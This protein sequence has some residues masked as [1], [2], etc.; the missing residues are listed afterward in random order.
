MFFDYITNLLNVNNPS[1]LLR[2]IAAVIILVTGFIIGSI[3][4]RL[5]KRV[6][7]DLEADR[8]LHEQTRVKVHVDEFIASAAAYFIY[9][10]A[11]VWAL[12][13]LGLTTTVLYV[14]FTGL[15]VIIVGFIL[16]AFKDFIPNA[17][18]GFTIYNS[19]MVSHGDRIKVA[20]IEGKVIHV[21]LLET[22]IQTN[23]KE[24]VF[25]PNSF[26]LK[27]ILIKSR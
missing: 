8:I 2:L 20:N 9:F 15:L 13:Q 22:K 7:H 27:N 14:I 12:N 16:L 19:D 10:A 26:M 21:G 11:I 25:I 24:V 23:K 5:I 4:S 1:F 6:L 3:V 18:A 17:F